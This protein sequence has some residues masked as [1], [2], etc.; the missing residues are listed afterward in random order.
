MVQQLNAAAVQS[1]GWLLGSLV[2]L[3][4]LAVVAVIAHSFAGLFRGPQAGNTNVIRALLA[5]VLVGA[6]V[7]IAAAALGMEGVEQTS[8]LLVGGVVA[9][10]ASA[11]A[12]YFA[13]RDAQ[14]TQENIIKAAFGTETVPD[15]RSKTV[16]QA[17][18]VISNAKLSLK[19]PDIAI[20]NPGY[21]VKN[22][23]PDPG[24]VVAQ[25][26]TIDIDVVP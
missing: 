1:P 8:N 7:L 16:Q 25:G 3:V 2:A 22:Q 13:S 23:H 6:L 14:S 4:G 24:T 10:A 20:G 9:S 26:T 12:F 19:L 15:L 11:V 18:A 17:Q 21:H 5:L